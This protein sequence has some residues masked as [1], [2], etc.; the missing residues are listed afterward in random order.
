[1]EEE[2]DNNGRL[3]S[4]E[5]IEHQDDENGNNSSISSVFK[6]PGELRRHLPP[7]K[8]IKLQCVICKKYI[9]KQNMKDH[10]KTVH[11]TTEAKVLGH[12]SVFE[13]FS[14]AKRPQVPPAGCGGDD[15][16]GQ[17]GTALAFIED[18][19]QNE[20]GDKD[21]TVD[22][23]LPATKVR[24]IS[25][26]ASEVVI[27]AGND[28]SCWTQEEKE[29]LLKQI[30]SMN[31][32]VADMQISMV[33]RSVEDIEKED[34]LDAMNDDT[35]IDKSRSVRELVNAFAE[36]SHNEEKKVCVLHPLQPS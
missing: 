26:D 6:A 13:M 7:S 21:I 30:E 4:I 35:F 15:L 36:L 2:K 12:K 25:K 33:N 3:S 8:I 11:K 18:V 17:Q 22:N 32:K 34:I 28:A 9:V 24:I 1:M 20:S 27:A 29:S 23:L 5:S 19:D 31:K 14:P 10:A 16:G